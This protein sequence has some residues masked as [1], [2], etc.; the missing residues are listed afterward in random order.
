MLI[1]DGIKVG[2]AL[3]DS[4]WSTGFNNFEWDKKKFPH[5]EDIVT[6]LHSKGI[7]VILWVTSMINNDT[8]IYEEAKKNNYLLNN[9]KL[10]KW[11]HGHGGFLDYF[12]PKAV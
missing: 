3:I 7:R 4:A 12:N 9:G 2:G 6:K 11:W 5:P 8:N 10:A 1:L